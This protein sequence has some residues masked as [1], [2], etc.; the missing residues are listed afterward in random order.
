MKFLIE[1]LKVSESFD[2]FYL[3]SRFVEFNLIASDLFLCNFLCLI[4][5]LLILFNFFLY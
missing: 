5:S 4:A 1:I 2:I 3:Q